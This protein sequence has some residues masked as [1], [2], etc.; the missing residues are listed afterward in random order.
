DAAAVAVAPVAADEAWRDMDLGLIPALVAEGKV[1]FVDVTADWCLTC[2]VN[3]KLVLDTDE[4][5]ARLQSDA[6][7]A[8]RG[9]WTLPS[10]EISR[11]LE[12]FGRYGIPFDAVY[13]PGLPDGL[14]LPELLTTDAVRK[15]MARA[16]GG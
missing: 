12:S 6:V 4:M 11:Y 16:A 7:V 10:E 1:V 14:A 9:D 15:A 8:M 2:Q 5:R 3:K 13:G